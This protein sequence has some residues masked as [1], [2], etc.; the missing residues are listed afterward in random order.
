MRQKKLPNKA[1][2][3]VP[4]PYHCVGNNDPPQNNNNNNKQTNKQKHDYI[5]HIH[6][7]ASRIMTKKPEYIYH[8]HTIASEEITE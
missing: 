2:L 1:W 6:T 8:M 5:Y 7:I 4:H 3:H